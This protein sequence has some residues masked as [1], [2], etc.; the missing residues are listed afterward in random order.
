MEGR[1][2]PQSDYQQREPE[3]V[4]SSLHSKGVQFEATFSKP[5]MSEL[6]YTTGPSTQLSF[7]KPFFGPAFTKPPHTKI[8]HP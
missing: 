5:V 8:P 1:V 4:I 3:L 2:D 7:T 6:T